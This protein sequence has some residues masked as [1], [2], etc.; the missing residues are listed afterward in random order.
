V[1][2]VC[3]PNLHGDVLWSLAAAR[4]LAR[5]E[6][7]QAD[8][9]LSER[10]RGLVDLLKV[11]RFVRDVYV[12]PACAPSDFLTP[13]G[14][15]KKCFHLH[16]QNM[17]DKTLLDG[18]CHS[19]GL[20]RQ[21]YW[22]DLPADCPK[23]KVPDGPFVTMVGKRDGS[24]WH[25]AFNSSFKEM[26]RMLKADGIPVVECGPPDS[27]LAIE[28]GAIDMTSQGFLEMAGIISKC[29]VFV[30][31]LSAPLVVADAFPDVRR[32]ALW[33]SSLWSLTPCTHSP[34]N[35]YLHFPNGRQLTELVQTIIRGIL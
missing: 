2:A 32:I 19:V 23:Q 12:E 1:I 9:W 27:Q 29:R 14:D 17:R 4:E 18:F 22:L 5:R 8:F 24:P 15:Y 20:D 11:Q 30:G 3:N 16:M 31:T 25:S 7:C 33:D 6:D 35:Y 21:G 26:T 10:A 13:R 28:D 34:V